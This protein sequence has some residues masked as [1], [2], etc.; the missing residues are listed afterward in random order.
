MTNKIGGDA[1][2]ARESAEKVWE[3]IQNSVGYGF[4]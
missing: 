4:N 1:I 3:I 2:K